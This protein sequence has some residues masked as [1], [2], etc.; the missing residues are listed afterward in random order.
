MHRKRAHYIHIVPQRTEQPTIR[1]DIW[2][3]HGPA[4]LLRARPV[5]SS[6]KQSRQRTAD[7]PTDPPVAEERFLLTSSPAVVVEQ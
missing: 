5:V 4:K 7:R 6:S 2:R 3:G 1:G